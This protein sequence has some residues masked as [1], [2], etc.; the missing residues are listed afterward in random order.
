MPAIARLDT[1]ICPKC[2]NG[3]GIWACLATDGLLADTMV[4]FRIRTAP[5]SPVLVL[6]HL[7]ILMPVYDIVG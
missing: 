4:L 6:V 3:K 7:P 2:M 5:I 1:P